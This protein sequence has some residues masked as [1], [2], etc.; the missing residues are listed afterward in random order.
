MLGTLSIPQLRVDL[1]QERTKAYWG[2][3]FLWDD[4]WVNAVTP[5][6]PFNPNLGAQVYCNQWLPQLTGPGG[7]ASHYLNAKGKLPRGTYTVYYTETWPRPYTDLE[8]LY[9]DLGN[10]V[11]SAPT[12]VTPGSGGTSYSFKVGPPKK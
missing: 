6:L 9:D 5:I 2:G 12:R 4:C 7:L 1:S 8:A 10:Q 3:P 11:N